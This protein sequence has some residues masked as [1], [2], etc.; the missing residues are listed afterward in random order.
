MIARWSGL[1]VSWRRTSSHQRP[2]VQCAMSVPAAV[3]APTFRSR[4]PRLDRIGAQRPGRRVA[5]RE[6]E[7]GGDLDGIGWACCQRRKRPYFEVTGPVIASYDGGRGLKP[8]ARGCGH[9]R[10]SLRIGTVDTPPCARRGPRAAT[11]LR[12]VYGLAGI[13]PGHLDAAVPCTRVPAE[14]G[15]RASGLQQLAQ[16]QII[17]PVSMEG[18][19]RV[20]SCGFVP[21]LARRSN[22]LWNDATYLLVCPPLYSGRCGPGHEGVPRSP[23]PVSVH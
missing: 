2:I 6:G 11:I 10:S 13:E 4:A 17:P 15:D 12:A 20:R 19:T 16:A 3:R 9:H 1:M 8:W 23:M 5:G 21:E 14:G 22:H 18:A 7:I